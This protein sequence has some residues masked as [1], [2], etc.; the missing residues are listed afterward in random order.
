MEQKNFLVPK[1]RKISAEEVTALLNKYK[2]DSVEKL[3][4]IKL[5]DPALAD[6]DAQVGD[7]I[8]VTRDKSF[9]GNSQFYRMV[10]NK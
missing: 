2:L 6:L 4:K 1:H 5:K 10:V 7:V 8:E 9:V 3:P